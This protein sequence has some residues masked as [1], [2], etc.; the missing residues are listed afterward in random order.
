MLEPLKVSYFSQD[1]Y[2]QSVTPTEALDTVRILQDGRTFAYARNGGTALGVGVLTTSLAADAD[3]I[4]ENGVEIAAAGAKTIKVTFAGTHTFDGD[5]YKDGWLWVND[6]TGEGQIA[7][8]KGHEASTA[9]NSYTVYIDLWDPIRVA[10]AV[11]TSQLS[12]YCNRQD[13]LVI[14]A[15]T[16]AGMVAGV[17]PI[18]VSANY[19]FWNQVKGP[20][21]VLIDIQ[22][23]EAIVIGNPV[24]RAPDVAGAVAGQLAAGN[25][26]LADLGTVM[27]TQA[28]AEYGLINLAIP[29]Y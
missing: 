17:A 23:A 13:K 26:V 9:A 24:C 3:T 12:V 5:Y 16:L 1:I 4:D 10:T 6:A 19:Y 22:G 29:G 2:Q 27:S 8:I 21:T 18:A 25:S 28:T 14:S 11:T 15:T 20:A 7:K